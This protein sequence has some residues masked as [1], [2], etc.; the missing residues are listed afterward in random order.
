MLGQSSIII[1]RS[2]VSTK[3]ADVTDVLWILRLNIDA[4]A[5][6]GGYLVL[7]IDTTSHS[8]R[9]ALAIHFSEFSNHQSFFQC[10]S[11]PVKMVKVNSTVIL[12]PHHSLRSGRI[13]EC[14]CTNRQN[15]YEWELGPRKH[16]FSGPRWALVLHS[17]TV[18]WQ[19]WAGH[20]RAQGMSYRGDGGRCKMRFNIKDLVIREI[21]SEIEK[22]FRDKKSIENHMNRSRER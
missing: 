8:P 12:N 6:R 20:R 21:S 15:F 10:R 7:M 17:R 1:A 14:F 18:Q 3:V 19:I 16:E 5:K 22:Q 4:E 9:F 2:D 11:L 13:E